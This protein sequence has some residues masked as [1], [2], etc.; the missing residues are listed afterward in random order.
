MVA[1]TAVNALFLLASI[2][3]RDRQDDQVRL[4]RCRRAG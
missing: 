2:A 3:Q 1:F 4:S